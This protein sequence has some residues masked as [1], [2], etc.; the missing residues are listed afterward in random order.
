M[1]SQITKYFFRPWTK[2]YLSVCRPRLAFFSR[3]AR[4]NMAPTSQ[5]AKEQNYLLF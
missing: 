5:I 1:W 2:K 3:G 4:K